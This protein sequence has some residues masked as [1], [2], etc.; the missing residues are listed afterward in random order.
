MVRLEKTVPA[1]PVAKGESCKFYFILL[2]SDLDFFHREFF[3][4]V[5]GVLFNVLQRKDETKTLALLTEEEIDGA[6]NK[7][8]L[9][10]LM[11]VGLAYILDRTASVLSQCLPDEEAEEFLE[12]FDGKTEN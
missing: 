5:L 11:K 6:G 8:H 7:P 4:A 12:V 3:L 2:F 10:L 1:T 9:G